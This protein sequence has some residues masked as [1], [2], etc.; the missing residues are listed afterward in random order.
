MTLYAKGFK[1]D[2]QRIANLLGVT[3][4]NDPLVEAGMSVVVDRLNRDAYRRIVAGYEPRS[5]DGIC[6]LELIV[7]LHIDNDEQRLR[8][9][10]LGP[11][12]ESITIAL[13]HTLVGPGVWEVHT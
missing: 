4:T 9:M 6:H 12:D 2:R 10:E 1:I 7:A 3:A 5:P 8:E 13:P 11:L